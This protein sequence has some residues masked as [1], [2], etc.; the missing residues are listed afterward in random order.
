[1]ISEKRSVS[2]YGLI[3]TYPQNKEDM[4]NTVTVD[5]SALAYNLRQIM[6]FS[7]GRR[8]MGI[9]KSDAYGHGLLPVA[10]TLER[11]E[12]DYLGV[13]HLHEA[14]ELRNEGIK[15]PIVI[16]C[17][18]LTRDE[19]REV[20][21]KG[22]TPV[23]FDLEVAEMLAQESERLGKRTHIH[24]KVDT[25][26]GRLGISL[27]E[28]GP[29]VKRI[30]ALKNLSL[31]AFTSHLSSA[32]DP[33]SDFTETQ[34][35]RFKKSI[36]LGRSMGLDLSLNHMAN[37]AGIMCHSDTHFEMVR[38]GIML[39]GGLPTPEFVN[40]IPLRPTMHFKGR[41]LQIRKLPAQTPVSYGRAYYTNSPCRVA[42]LSGGYGDGLPRSMSNR[43][44]VL[45]GS[46]R[47]PIVG[48]ICMNL[49][50]CDISG[51][52]DVK[53]GD[54]VIFLGSQGQEIITADDIARWAGTISYEV[55]C[56]IGQRNKK[57]Y[58]L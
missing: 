31:E 39:Y 6:L 34:V 33:M 2:F 38:P 21:E 10:R 7:G 12:I 44:N 26:M 36:G 28:I 3:Q 37:S 48:M 11:C 30:L 42:V 45:V 56:S 58:I 20:V 29:F 27:E 17:G 46:K 24:L 1:L 22:L 13:A 53:T 41:I 55:F 32:A 43:G 15:V 25:G 54:E 57:E 35:K 4:P 23:L 19:S 16:L 18:I 8:I 50:I 49:T 9:V 52:E 14:R 40:P 51:L 47:V 5:L